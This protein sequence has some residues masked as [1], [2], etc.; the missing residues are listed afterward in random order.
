VYSQYSK[1]RNPSQ[2]EDKSP[3]AA[4]WVFLAGENQPV[5]CK[6]NIVFHDDAV[7][8]TIGGK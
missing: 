6:L 1:I 2:P 4:S 8:G 5:Q 7:I 3:Y